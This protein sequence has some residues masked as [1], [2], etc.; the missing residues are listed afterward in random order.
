[1]RKK[2][3]AAAIVMVS[4]AAFVSGLG[5]AET[6]NELK[7]ASDFASIKDASQRSIA[8]F[9]EAGK[10]LT[11]PRCLNCHPAGNSPTQS[12]DMHPHQPLVVRGEADL[13]APGM[14][15]GTC[16]GPTNFD[17]G[18]VPGNPQWHIAPI[19][20]AWQHKSLGAICA[21]IKD[22][23]RNG[24]KSK[25]QL[26]DHMTN[27][28]LVGWAW[29]PGAGREPAPGTQ[30]IFGELIRAWVTSGAMCPPA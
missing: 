27:D 21:Q 4:F 28:S 13:G 30:K 26:I 20:M 19:G 18:H 25:E 5:A 17:P 15:C 12:M 9:T 14:R 23:A 8:I 29:A 3:L 1:M 24:G 22:P 16:H 10:V 11:H 6:G 7:P 2:V